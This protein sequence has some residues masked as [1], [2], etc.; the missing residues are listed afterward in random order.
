MNAREAK[1]HAAAAL[2]AAG[3]EYTKLSAK[4]HSFGG[5]GYGSAVFVTPHGLTLPDA[6]IA[7]VKAALK[8]S[9]VILKTPKILPSN[10]YTIE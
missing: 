7:D 6:R 2:D 1:K 5:L 3:L 10:P 4:T 9:G 8:G